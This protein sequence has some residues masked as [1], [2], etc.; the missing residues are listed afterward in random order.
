[1]R[2]RYVPVY[3][4]VRL[5]CFMA[6]S[7][8]AVAETVP[9]MTVDQLESRLGADDLAVFDV[10]SE[11]DWSTADTLINGA[12]RVSPNE[13]GQWVDSFPKQKTFV[14]YCT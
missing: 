3:V 1:M 11:R 8:G 12:V 6:T 9:R 7:F 2:T 10:R 14:L 13:V 5:T 4:I